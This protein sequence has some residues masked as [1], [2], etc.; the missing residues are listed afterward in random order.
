MS[1]GKGV[2]ASMSRGIAAVRGS[3]T[4][5]GNAANALYGVADYVTQPLGF[6]L[7]A[8]YL[9]MRLGLPQYGL[10]MLAIAVVAS[11][12]TI[13]SGF[14]DATIK[15]VSMYRGRNDH[16]AVQRII[17]ATLAINAILGGVL[18]LVVVAFSRFAVDHVFKIEPGLHAVSIRMLQVAG[19]T[20]LV[21]SVEMVFISTLRA[22][23]QYGPTVKVSVA[24]RALN[25]IA[26]VVLA[27][28]GHGALAIML[29]TL[30]IAIFGLMVQAVTVRRLVGLASYLP[31]LD[32]ASRRE[33]FGFGLFSW[34]QALASVV[35][36]HADRFLIGAFLG[37]SAV[38]VY[39]ICVQGAQPVHGLAAAGLNFLF[40]HIS[41]RH[42]SGGVLA[43]HRAFR[44][45]LWFNIAIAGALCVPLMVLSKPIL[46]AWMGPAFANSAATLLALVALSWGILAINVVPHYTLLALGEVKFVSAVNVLGGGL[47]LVAAALLIPRFGILGAAAARVFYGLAVSSNFV[48]LSRSFAERNAVGIGY[49]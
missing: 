14:G 6:L 18:A 7:A 12:G 17:R 24:T 3:R 5:R 25:I 46:A 41:S 23:E 21:R 27:A 42:E 33:L 35:F 10:W 16:D 8:P 49:A 1:G 30:I 43:S 40:P 28:I 29:G 39:A 11:F 15:Y 2:A 32:R 48:K 26:A 19:I 44:A 9:V 47:S 38:G 45:A 36:N 13:S 37:T 31:W 4:V 22:Y 20:L 34:L